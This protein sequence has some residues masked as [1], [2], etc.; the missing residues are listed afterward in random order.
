MEEMRQAVIEEIDHEI[1]AEMRT[2]CGLPKIKL[3]GRGRIAPPASA[4]VET[5]PNS[6]ATDEAGGSAIPHTEPG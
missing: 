6:V 5:P 4:A 1:L 2:K 3:V